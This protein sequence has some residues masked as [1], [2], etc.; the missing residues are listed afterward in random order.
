MEFSLLGLFIFGMIFFV[1]GF[2]GG[3]ATILYHRKVKY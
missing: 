2:I 3:V 1:F